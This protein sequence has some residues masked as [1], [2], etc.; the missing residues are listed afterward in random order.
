MKAKISSPIANFLRNFTLFI[1][2]LKHNIFVTLIEIEI[3]F[4]FFKINYGFHNCD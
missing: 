3:F 4:L 2:K 1:L